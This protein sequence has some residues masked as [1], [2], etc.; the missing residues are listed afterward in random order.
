MTTNGSSTLAWADLAV[1]T[2]AR[3]EL[4]GERFAIKPGVRV[5]AT[6]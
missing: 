3:F 2:E 4:D 5:E 6:A 1:W